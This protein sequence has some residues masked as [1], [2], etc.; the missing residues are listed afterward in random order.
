MQNGFL[1]MYVFTGNYTF[2]IKGAS[3]TG[4]A[5]GDLIFFYLTDQNGQIPVT[6]ISAPN[7]DL[8]EEPGN[9]S[10]FSTVDIT[11]TAE[12]YRTA[13]YRGIQVFA[14]ETSIACANMIPLPGGKKTFR[15]NM[16]LKSR[17]FRWFL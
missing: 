7:E 17:I 15:W 10:P 5:A 9:A 11:V 2:P 13:I 8:S 12:G 6:V 3:V 16:I 4:F 1:K 14:G